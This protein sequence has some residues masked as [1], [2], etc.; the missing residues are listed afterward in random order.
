MVVGLFFCLL[1]W[2]CPPRSRAHSYFA[3]VKVKQVQA[4]MLIFIL[5]PDTGPHINASVWEKLTLFRIF[6]YSWGHPSVLGSQHTATFGQ[7]PGCSCI[8]CYR[9]PS[10]WAAICCMGTLSPLFSLLAGYILVCFQLR[11]SIWDTIGLPESGQVIIYV[12]PQ[13]PASSQQL[14]FHKYT[15][16]FQ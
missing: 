15:E 5:T 12:M 10:F 3:Y 4:L 6:L 1:S 8:F 9:V 14:T 11:W 16:R 2:L 7:K 13:L